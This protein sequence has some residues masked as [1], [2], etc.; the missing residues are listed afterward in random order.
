M[1]RSVGKLTKDRTAS[2]NEY[3]LPKSLVDDISRRGRIY[4]VGGTVR[5]RFISPGIEFK[6]RDFLVTS[7]PFNELTRLLKFHGRVGLVG[8]SF[9]VIKFTP[10]YKTVTYDIALPRKEISIGSGHKDFEVNFDHNLPVEVDLFRRD[11]TINSIAIDISSGAIIDPLGG[12]KDIRDKMIRTTSSNSFLDDPLRMLRA[13]QFA[14]RFSF[15]I[16]PATLNEIKINHSLINTVSAER[17]QEELNKLL[18]RALE[19]SIGFRIMRDTGILKEILPELQATVGIDQPGPYH[20]YDVFEHTMA[21]IDNTPRRLPVRLAALFHDISKPQTRELV[22][23]GA[24]FYGHE[25]KGAGIARSVLKRLRYSKDIIDDVR[26]LVYRHMYT[27]KVTDKGLRRLIRNVGQ[28]RIFNLL[29]LRRA[30]I[31]AQGRGLNVKQVDRFERRIR[32]ELERKP[33]FTVKDLAIN[34]YDLMENFDLEESPI[35]GKILKYLL[36]YVLD[37]PEGNKR[38]ILLAKAKEFLDT[39]Q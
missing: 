19:P 1:K 10:R 26:I 24:T 17:I 13:I 32:E 33:P 14:A 18:T 23:E 37:N 28:E 25:R 6:D 2:Y 7:I 36:E 31:I 3:G 22:D 8:K 12:R 5:D 15:S 9:G 38:E 20:R 30:D 29:D 27:D 11:F 39:T 4:E 35:I 21:T 16:E 34:G